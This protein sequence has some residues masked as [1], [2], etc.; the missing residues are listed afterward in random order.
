MSIVLGDMAG[1]ELGAG[2]GALIGG[3]GFIEVDGIEGLG[4]MT[5]SGN[6]DKSLSAF[7][8]IVISLVGNGPTRRL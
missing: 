8:S 5:G 4:P 7:V 6:G 2:E 3:G 1:A